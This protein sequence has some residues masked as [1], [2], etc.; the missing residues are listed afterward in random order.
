MNEFM[1]VVERVVRPVEA[2][3]TKKLRMREELLAHL[4]CIYEEELARLG[5]EA[6]ARAEAIRRFGDP[7]ALTV[8]LQHSVKWSDRV[9]ARLNRAFGWRPGE[10]AVRYSA[11]LSSLV[12]LLIL[13]WLLFALVLAGLGRPNEAAVP[14]VEEFLRLFG[15]VFVFV[16]IS[17]FALSIFS[18]RMRDAMFG[19]LG[20]RQS[21][22]RVVGFAGL[23]LLSFP[24]LGALF[25]WVS[26]GN[27]FV[28]A[29]ELSSAR[30]LV[31]SAAG[32]LFVTLY[33]VWFVRKLGPGQLRHFEWASLDIGR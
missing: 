4:T 9:D 31:A 6:A 16:P 20:T 11:R 10:P 26:L 13:P 3:P 12:G 21:W 14:T 33:M 32:Y 23:S 8:E 30:A 27:V 22:R 25:F 24:A 2:G 17:V 5:D 19:A 18:I 15:G 7:V 1:V 28:L 29:E